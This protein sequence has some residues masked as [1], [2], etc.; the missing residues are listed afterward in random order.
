MYISDIDGALLVQLSI[1][2]LYAALLL[3]SRSLSA[4]IPE[5]IYVKS[6]F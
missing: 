2:T 1:E 5:S 4:N 3:C 6:S